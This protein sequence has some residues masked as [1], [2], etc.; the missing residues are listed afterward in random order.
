MTTITPRAV[1]A[2]TS[3][4][5][6]PM[7][8]RPTTTRSVPAASTSAVTVVAERMIRACAPF[9][10]V[11]QLLGGEPR[12]DVDLVARL[13]EAVE[14]AIGDLLSYEYTGHGRHLRGRPLRFAKRPAE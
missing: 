10:R 8:A 9:D 3:T 12:L 14:S 4:L 6:R 13:A 11:E 2:A 1:A 5:S 7:P